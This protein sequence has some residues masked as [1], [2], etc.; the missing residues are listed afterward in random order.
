[1]DIYI[2]QK[3]PEDADST[4]DVILED[5]TDDNLHSNPAVE[6][7]TKDTIIVRHQYY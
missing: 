1:M 7:S 3:Q 4:D 5:A 2:S 6:K